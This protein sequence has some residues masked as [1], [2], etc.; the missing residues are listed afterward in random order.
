MYSSV[1]ALACLNF[2][3]AAQWAHSPARHLH[4]NAPGRSQKSLKFANSVSSLDSLDVLSQANG[5]MNSKERIQHLKTFASLALALNR[6]SR[7]PAGAAFNPAASRPSFLG[8]SFSRVDAAARSRDCTRG[9]CPVLVSK[10]ALKAE[11]DAIEEDGSLMRDVREDLKS[12]RAFV[13]NAVEK[14]W[15][16]LEWVADDLKSDVYIVSVALKQNWRALKYAA[17]KLKNDREF[18]LE[19]VQSR[20]RALEYVGDGMKNDKS[21]VLASVRDDGLNLQH[22]GATL[23]AD[24]EVVLAA[25]QSCGRAIDY[26]SEDLKK[27]GEIT[28]AAT[29]QRIVEIIQTTVLVLVASLIGLVCWSYILVDEEKFNKLWF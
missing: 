13:M 2:L 29:Q 28:A 3:S 25:V 12:D 8:G 27:D 1:L 4:S 16:A 24:R 11:F 10:E 5:H 9:G 14:N 6:A 23:K 18:A 15:T 17:E 20:G 7:T 21:I 26:A 19:V 22:A